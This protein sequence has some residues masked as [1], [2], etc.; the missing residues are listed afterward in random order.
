MM[1]NKRWV[2]GLISG[3]LLL[4]GGAL[5]PTILRGAN[6]PN[7][8]TPAPK[9]GE[10]L[11][12][13]FDA[14]HTSA[15]PTEDR[16]GIENVH[17]LRRTW[18]VRLGE[19]ISE[20][21]IVG[22]V[23]YVASRG[24]VV[25]AMSSV[26]GRQQWRAKIDGYRISAPAV[27]DA[28]IF[29]VSDGGFLAAVSGAD[30]RLLWRRSFTDVEGG[31]APPVV[32][33][34]VVYA[35]GTD[36]VTFD[37]ASGQELWRRPIGCFWCSPAI[38]EGTLYIAAGPDSGNQ[39]FALATSAGLTRW[40]ARLPRGWLWGDSAAVADGRVYVQVA[41]GSR[42]RNLALAAFDSGTGRAR[43]KAGGGRSEILPGDG[44]AVDGGVV[45]YASRSGALSALRAST[46][47]RLW[48]RKC[49]DIVVEPVVANGIVYTGAGRTLFALDARTGQRLWS[50]TIQGGIGTYPVV[51]G[52]ALYVGSGVGRLLRFE[53]GPGKDKPRCDLP[54]SPRPG[55]SF[56]QVL[57]N[58]SY[59]DA[60]TEFGR[61]WLWD[62]RHGAESSLCTVLEARF[63]S[64]GRVTEVLMRGGK[65]VLPRSK[66]KSRPPGIPPDP[67]AAK[68]D[69]RLTLRTQPETNRLFGRVNLTALP[70]GRTRVVIRTK[71]TEFNWVPFI[72]AR[73][74]T[75][76][77]LQ[78]IWERRSSTV[79]ARP[80]RQLRSVPHLV[81]VHYGTLASAGCAGMAWIR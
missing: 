12:Y 56:K 42:R 74:R 3:V 43:W 31:F 61:T 64:G 40:R 78:P 49:S 24:G 17:R 60:S 22:D 46:G 79:I 70:G 73:G 45:Y 2:T 67:D 58:G 76:I 4:A 8:L 34:S 1:R 19:K 16:L 10:W 25:R 71:R 14:A 29:V 21:A 48:A 20:P 27:S 5:F 52:G 35:A 69:M 13:R 36:T 51:A 32:S 80:L 72:E 26:T 30:G 59:P 28:G 53:L 75:T 65:P 37:A 38:A 55:Q 9:D 50:A 68:A 77:M 63:D 15:N 54:A 81:C 66:R 62:Y 57:R 7:D 18:S 41:R 33:G 44:P 11:Q 47:K 23:L 39:L 6:G